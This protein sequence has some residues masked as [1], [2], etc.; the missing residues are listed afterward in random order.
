MNHIY[1][2]VFI[3]HNMYIYIYTHHIEFI[4]CLHSW[5]LTKFLEVLIVILGMDM[6][7]GPS[8]SGELGHF[9]SGIGGYPCPFWG[10][11]WAPEMQYG[12][13]AVP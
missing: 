7:F 9:T 1:I 13:F 12:R 10:A 5:L 11:G 6:G 2:Y 8:F 4:Y 3:N